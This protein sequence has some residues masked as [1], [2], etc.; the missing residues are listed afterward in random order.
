MDP[1]E[2]HQQWHGEGEL[3]KFMILVGI[4]LLTVLLVAASRPLVFDWIIPAAL[5]WEPALPG[6][7]P[8]DNLAP[9]PAVLPESTEIPPEPTPLSPSTRELVISAPTVTPLPTATLQIYEVQPGD[10]LTTIARRYGVTIDAL[11]AANNINNPNRII[12][13]EVLLIPAP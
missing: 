11:M 6:A 1:E 5:G 7:E 13:G 2:E 12:P 4:L 9:L 10:N 3:V 8:D